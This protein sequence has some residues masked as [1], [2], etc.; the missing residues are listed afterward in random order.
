MN[1][2]QISSNQ[3]KPVTKLPNQKNHINLANHDGLTGSWF[4]GEQHG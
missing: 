3:H 1:Q 2:L 4:A